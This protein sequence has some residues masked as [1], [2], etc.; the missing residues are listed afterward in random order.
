MANLN[1]SGRV[2]LIELKPSAGDSLNDMLSLAKKLSDLHLCVV[3][4]THNMTEY[5]ISPK[6]Q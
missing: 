6:Q 1:T 5:T 2:Q 4:F 3:K